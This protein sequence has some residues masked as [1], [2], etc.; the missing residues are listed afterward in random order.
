M[1]G[2]LVRLRWVGRD[3][4]GAMV[5]Q[6]PIADNARFRTL[7]RAPPA[8][9]KNDFRCAAPVE[10]VATPAVDDRPPRARSFRARDQAAIVGAWAVDL[11]ATGD[12]DG[13]G[14][15]RTPRATVRAS[16]I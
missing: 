7:R 12:R 6:R 15:A 5:R 11:P 4:C 8:P 10:R 2:L 3:A 13:A 9:V 1:H 14:V 16:P